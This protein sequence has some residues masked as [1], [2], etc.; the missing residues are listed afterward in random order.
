M[1]HT[2]NLINAL[3][4]PKFIPLNEWEGQGLSKP[5]IDPESWYQFINGYTD[6]IEKGENVMIAEDGSV[7]YQGSWYESWSEVYPTEKEGYFK[8]ENYVYYA[9]G[10]WY[11][12][13]EI[14]ETYAREEF[15]MEQE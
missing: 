15:E 8:D 11:G 5:T 4:E 1:K 10:T 6:I 14:L 12:V 7:Y 2:E 3:E 13:L 9:E